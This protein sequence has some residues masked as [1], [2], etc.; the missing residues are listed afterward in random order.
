MDDFKDLEYEETKTRD[1]GFKIDISDIAVFGFFALA[2]A[3]TGVLAYKLG[4]M[5]GSQRFAVWISKN[6]RMAHKELWALNPN[7]Y[8]IALGKI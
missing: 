3:T 4:C 6:A 7:V 5:T 1:D 2:F 8:R